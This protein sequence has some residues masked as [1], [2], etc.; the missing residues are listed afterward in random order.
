M[1][2]LHFFSSHLFK[3]NNS[4]RNCFFP[5]SFN[6]IATG[7]AYSSPGTFI[8]KTVTAWN[9]FP[10][11]TQHTNW[12]SNTVYICH[13]KLL[14]LL[15][16]LLSHVSLKKAKRKED[17]KTGKDFWRL[18]MQ[19]SL[20]LAFT[21]RI[22]ETKCIYNFNSSHFASTELDA[23]ESWTNNRH[24]W[25]CALIAETGTYYNCLTI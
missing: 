6:P 14:W 4:F 23:S 11:I 8:I 5:P 18:W 13:Q 12:C 9:Y 25:K 2:K 15:F 16:S 19:L 24:I 22:T 10:I 21:R 7:D 1:A 3:R 20:I 17:R